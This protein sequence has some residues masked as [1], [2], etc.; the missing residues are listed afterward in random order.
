MG[1]GHKDR[2]RE[3]R[4]RELEQVSTEERLLKEEAQREADEKNEAHQ[5]LKQQQHQQ[6][7][8]QVQPEKLVETCSYRSLK[9]LSSSSKRDSFYSASDTDSGHGS[10]T[11]TSSDSPKQ[12]QTEE[13]VEQKKRQTLVKGLVNIGNTCF[14]NVV[15]QVSEAPP[16]FYSIQL[17][18]HR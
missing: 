2:R 3:Q 4:A 12:T 6:N 8:E 14:F 5:K 16:Y 10:S 15:I 1:K 9:Y 7:D 18:L 17:L 11:T 13:S